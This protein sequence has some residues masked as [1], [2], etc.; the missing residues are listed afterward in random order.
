MTHQIFIS[1]ARADYAQVQKICDALRSNN[2]SFW[3]DTKDLPMGGDFPAHIAEAIEN[4]KIIVFVSSEQSSCSEWVTREVL[5]AA[6]KRKNIFPVRL[7]DTPFNRNLDIILPG[8]NHFDLPEVE[9]QG[10]RQFVV[11][12]LDQLNPGKEGNNDLVEF[13]RIPDENDP[14]LLELLKIYSLL[15]DANKNAAQEAI[16]KTLYGGHE[17]HHACLFLLKRSGIAFG[18]ADVSYFTKHKMLYISYIGVIT[19]VLPGERCIYTLQIGEGLLN[20]FKSKDMQIDEIV[21]ENENEKLYRF[22]SRVL[23]SKYKLRAYMIDVEF[24]QPRILAD[25]SLEITDETAFHLSWIPVNNST[26]E[27]T[28]MTREKVLSIV[29]SVYKNIFLEITDGSPR[30]EYEKYLEKLINNYN[31][32]LPDSIRLIH[33]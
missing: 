20:Y 32:Q 12:I 30:K 23:Y 9:G 1:Y 27:F 10:I 3:I 18:F 11:K 33:T 13:K 15:F 25:N 26:Q 19:S 7:D 4:A 8:H 2:I 21:F 16:I 28:F 22:F 29:R 17:H 24:I 6:K 31:D 14:D 5:Y